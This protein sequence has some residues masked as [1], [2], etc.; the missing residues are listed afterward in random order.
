MLFIDAGLSAT[1][2]RYV[3]MGSFK[4]VSISFPARVRKG[5]KDVVVEDK[6]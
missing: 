4:N 6:M 3:I 5:L 1:E 2:S